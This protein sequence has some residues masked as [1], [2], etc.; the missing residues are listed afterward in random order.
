MAAGQKDQG[1][2]EARHQAFLETNSYYLIFQT[3]KVVTWWLVAYQVGTVGNRRR[4]LKDA[5]GW[6]DGW[7]FVDTRW[8][9]TDTRAGW[10][11]I[12]AGTNKCPS[13]HIERGLLAWVHAHY[14]VIRSRRTR[15][16]LSLWFLVP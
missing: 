7:K 11:G 16:L 12:A 3:G 13:K 8:C 9:L 14:T 5:D 15:V 10:V 2:S 1:S 4:G 6:M